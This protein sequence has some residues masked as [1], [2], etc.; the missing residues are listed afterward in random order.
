MSITNIIQ[1][2]PVWVFIL[3]FMLLYLGYSQSKDREVNIYRVYILPSVII[4]LSLFGMFSTF[5]ISFTSLNLWFVSM[6]L[7]AVFTMKKISSKNISYD[8][9][10]KTFKI[11]GS[12]IPMILILVI[13][14]IKYLIGF[15]SATNPEFLDNINFIY[16][17]SIIYGLINGVFLARTLNILKTKNS[18]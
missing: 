8:K 16:L 6:A 12:W 4:G 1:N 5:D 17:V 13:F 3:L 7:C 11:T 15:I 9:N 2:T 14:S 18:K 10:K